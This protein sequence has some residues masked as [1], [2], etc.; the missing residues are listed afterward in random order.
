MQSLH[1][2]LEKVFRG[3]CHFDSE[4]ECNMRSQPS[5]GA[6]EFWTFWWNCMDKQD[7]TSVATRSVR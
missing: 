7:G 5:G 3:R 6:Q 1:S 2:S 4:I